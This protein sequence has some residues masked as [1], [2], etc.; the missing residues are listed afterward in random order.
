MQFW[1]FLL[2]EGAPQPS[3]GEDHELRKLVDRTA[4]DDCLVDLVSDSVEIIETLAPRRGQR[5]L[6]AC[7]PAGVLQRILCITQ[8]VGVWVRYEAIAQ[9]LLGLRPAT[10]GG[11]QVRA[12]SKKKDLEIIGNLVIDLNLIKNVEGLRMAGLIGEDDCQ[13]DG[14]VNSIWEEPPPHA[15]ELF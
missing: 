3:S 4:A 2:D 5:I 1:L 8:E 15:Q 9:R 6:G 10:H 14:Q 12:H 11:E 13:L 7:S